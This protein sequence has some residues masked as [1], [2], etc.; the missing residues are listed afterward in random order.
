M[1]TDISSLSSTIWPYNIYIL[2]K[3][4]GLC[5]EPS[6][7]HCEQHYY[8]FMASIT[9]VINLFV[10]TQN[11]VGIWAYTKKRHGTHYNKSDNTKQT[12][13]RSLCFFL[14]KTKRHNFLP[15]GVKQ[16]LYGYFGVSAYNLASLMTYN[17]LK[18]LNPAHIDA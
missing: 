17:N 13:W 14:K 7:C 11:L 3:L 2:P 5:T 6:L 4:L 16:S 12:H 10:R 18:H 8:V 9:G 1:S 15:A